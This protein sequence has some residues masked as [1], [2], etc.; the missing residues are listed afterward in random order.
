MQSKVSA[1][2]DPVSDTLNQAIE[3][4]FSEMK[5]YHLLALRYVTFRPSLSRQMNSLA[6]ECQGRLDRLVDADI[7]HTDAV[8]CDSFLSLPLMSTVTLK[9]KHFFVFTEAMAFQLLDEAHFLAHR[10]LHQYQAWANRLSQGDLGALLSDIL[11]QKGAECRVLH[12]YQT[13]W[14]EAS[15]CLAAWPH[16]CDGR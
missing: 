7:T 4:E 3:H 10:S 15:P 13:Q 1:M 11:A 9:G 6:I 12:V 16:A 8:Y 5:R 14:P 2:R